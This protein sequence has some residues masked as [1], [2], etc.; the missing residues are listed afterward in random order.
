MKL[1]PNLSKTVFLEHSVAEEQFVVNVAAGCDD[2]E[3]MIINVLCLK[4]ET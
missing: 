3:N 2:D 4:A 1:Q